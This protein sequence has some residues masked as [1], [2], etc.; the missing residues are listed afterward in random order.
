MT[1]GVS[2]QGD[3]ALAA[4]TTHHDIS[5]KDP[6]S[7]ARAADSGTADAVALPEGMAW[8]GPPGTSPVTS[9]K[10][11][12]EA[13]DI[14]KRAIFRDRGRTGGCVGR[15]K[16]VPS[17]GSVGVKDKTAWAETI[18]ENS[19]GIPAAR[20]TGTRPPD[21]DRPVADTP[22]DHR[23]TETLSPIRGNCRNIRRAR[24]GQA[25]INDASKIDRSAPPDGRLDRRSPRSRSEGSKGRPAT[26]P[27]CNAV[28]WP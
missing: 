18:A 16:R 22:P 12:Q 7:S 10:H 19:T 3:N 4:S 20:A 28:W 21:P 9:A 24:V 1:G 11:K 27:G 17:N 6:V 23:I 25:S 2:G 14:E 15:V 13:V 8:S 26:S 5:S